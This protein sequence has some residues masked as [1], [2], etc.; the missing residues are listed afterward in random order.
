M[1]M[2]AEACSLWGS[3]QPSPHGVSGS[4]AG[5]AG[6]SVL[7]LLVGKVCVV[8][9][10]G[11]MCLLEVVP[12]GHL[13]LLVVAGDCLTAVPGSHPRNITFDTFSICIT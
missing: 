11:L 9:R 3:L 10:P 13:L 1:L 5:G 4:G 7:P 6:G 12:W 8:L 2:E